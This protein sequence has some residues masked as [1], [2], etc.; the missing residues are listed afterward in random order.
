MFQPLH[1]QLPLHFTSHGETPT[2]TQ[3]SDIAKL[4]VRAFPLYL[5]D[6]RKIHPCTCKNNACDSL[7]LGL[8]RQWRQ[9]PPASE[10]YYELL[11]MKIFPPETGVTLGF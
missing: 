1:E 8:W 4:L 5:K 9:A 11:E 3:P 10:N 2:Q 7:Y 6:R